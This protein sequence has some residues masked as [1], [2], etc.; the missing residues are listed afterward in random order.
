MKNNEHANWF[1]SRWF[2]RLFTLGLA[3]LLFVYVN[4]SKLDNVRQGSDNGKNSILTSNKKKTISVPLELNVNSNRYVATGYPQNVKVKI[5]GPA[6]L[7]TTTANTQNFKIYA[8]L[9]G[10]GTGKHKVTVKQ[11]GLNKDISYQIKPKTITV[12]IQARKT[13]TVPINVVLSQKEVADGYTLGKPTTSAE[14]ATITGSVS[15]V[16]RVDRLIA[17]VNVS[18]TTKKSINKRVTL[19]AVDSKGNTVSVVITPQTTNVVVPVTSSDDNSSSSS[20][21]NST[22]SKSKQT[23]SSESDDSSSSSS[24]SASSSSSS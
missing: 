24:S 15:E 23:S 2:F 19:Q 13:V 9:T 17:S 7:I 5:S 4:G 20:S 8:D 14:T 11:S 1:N 3:I 22:S 16:E 18:K 12:D 6:A 21:S 10:L